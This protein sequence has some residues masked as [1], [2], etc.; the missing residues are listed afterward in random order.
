MKRSDTKPSVSLTDDDYS[1]TG[2]DYSTL[3]NSYDQKKK[4]L[5]IIR[6]SKM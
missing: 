1:F 6:G 2:L 3:V 5:P 4:Y